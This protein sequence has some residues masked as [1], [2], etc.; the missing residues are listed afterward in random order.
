MADKV[1]FTSYARIDN[2]DEEVSAV[3]ERLVKR[4]SQRLGEEVETLFDIEDLKNGMQWQER[5]GAALRELKVMVCLCSPG[6]LKSAFCAKEFAVFRQRIDA[7]GKDAI[8]ILPVVWDPT[9][10][11]QTIR[12]YHQS[13]DPRL[14]ADYMLVGLRQYSQLKAQQDNYIEIVN[15][16]AEDIHNA[17]ASSTLTKWP[18]EV[19]FDELP[20]SFDDPHEEPYGVTLTVLD[21]KKSRWKPGNVHPT[22]G[23]I[24]GDVA[25]VVGTC[26]RDVPY[27][28]AKLID[29][30]KA[31]AKARQASIFVIDFANI[32]NPPWDQLLTA[33]DQSG[34]TNF[35]VLIGR[36]KEDIPAATDV[37]QALA[38]PLP[39]TAAAGAHHAFFPL[40]DLQAC[41][42][43]L[44]TAATV[45]VLGLVNEDKAAN[46]VAKTISD[47][48]RDH[49]IDVGR[50]APLR[51]PGAQQ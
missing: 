51:G 32:T 11:P 44:N 9:P 22:I 50:V 25:R 6:Y 24:F 35:A 27:D 23:E 39:V 5:L 29:H 2:T 1:F 12:W 26:W 17:H 46:V 40:D 45:L 19:L 18:Q 8:G 37:Q 31:A 16:I 42:D 3:V 14:P 34:Q 49:G 7:A 28:V 41:K 10:L 15:A 30:L 13:K 33:L 21:E 48:A 38:K 4:V 47:D 36:K 20:D 43:A